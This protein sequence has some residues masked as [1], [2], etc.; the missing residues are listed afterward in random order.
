MA[1][2]KAK[3]NF[4]IAKD[5]PMLNLVPLALKIWD[6]KTK[7]VSKSYTEKCTSFFY[8]IFKLQIYV[9]THLRLF[10]LSISD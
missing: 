4:K 10:R 3:N 2:N 8:K 1:S 6:L 5:H 9:F 7:E